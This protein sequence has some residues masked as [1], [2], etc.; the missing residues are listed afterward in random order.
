MAQND[1]K[2]Q[3]SLPYSYTEQSQVDENTMRI[4]RQKS[5]I[6]QWQKLQERKKKA[7]H[8]LNK[9]EINWNLADAYIYRVASQINERY[10]TTLDWIQR[11]FS[12][13]N[14]QPY[15]LNGSIIYFHF[16]PGNQLSLL[17]TE[18]EIANFLHINFSIDEAL[19][20]Y[21]SN[22][23]IPILRTFLLNT[24]YI[25]KQYSPEKLEILF[26]HDG[27]KLDITKAKT[28][29]NLSP[30]DPSTGLPS[31]FNNRNIVEEIKN[32]PK[33]EDRLLLYASSMD[34]IDNPQKYTPEE[35]EEQL[36]P[37]S[38]DSCLE[39][40]LEITEEAKK[41]T[42]KSYLI[43]VLEYGKN[44][45]SN[46]R[47]QLF[48]PLI[49]LITNNPLSLFSFIPPTQKEAYALFYCHRKFFRKTKFE[50]YFPKKADT[51]ARIQDISAKYI[52][53][54]TKK[55]FEQTAQG[56]SFEELETDIYKQLSF[57][58]IP[59]YPFFDIFSQLTFYQ[60]GSPPSNSI[61][62]TLTN[63]NI[64]ECIALFELI[65]KTYL[66]T[67][68][69][70]TITGQ[71][72]SPFT[73]IICKNPF[74]GRAFLCDIFFD[75]LPPSLLY[76]NTHTIMQQSHPQLTQ[77]TNLSTLLAMSMNDILANITIDRE[78]TA[79]MTGAQLQKLNL[80]LKGKTVKYPNNTLGT[81]SYQSKCQYI[82]VAKHNPFHTQ[83]HTE[84]HLS[85]DIT[86]VQY[87]PLAAK[88]K[89][90]LVLSALYWTLAKYSDFQKLP[91]INKEM[92][93]TAPPP[94]DQAI[95]DFIEIS[96]TNTIPSI[97]KNMISKNLSAN[98]HTSEAERDNIRNIL[99]IKNY[100]FT[101]TG[102]LIEAL[103]DWYQA[104]YDS[105]ITWSSNEI[106]DFFKSKYP[107]SFYISYCKA[108]N[109][110]YE[111][112]KKQSSGA[113][114]FYGLKVDYQK[115][116]DEI[117]LAKEKHSSQDTEKNREEFTKYFN[118]IMKHAQSNFEEFLNPSRKFI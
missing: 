73:V 42:L 86:M 8:H 76:R 96:C 20:K 116:K 48:Q 69:Y 91:C 90:E 77:E 108:N 4:R 59:S 28:I 66:G 1:P 109:I 3:D 46:I 7:Q 81:I 100:P 102:D 30:N 36:F 111:Y 32:S 97:T 56:V 74:Y 14:I 53:L 21:F 68:L 95:T 107:K 93:Y 83:E 31:F 54:H 39:H 9:D 106:K 10:P 61:L 26:F 60:N 41:N 84:L 98:S 25:L 65:T 38:L 103:Q 101:I 79:P 34:Y 87:T 15:Q 11:I 57:S 52:L 82:Y 62:Y 2:K 44:C 72:S 71:K 40:T 70:N 45:C 105:S 89:W 94:K 33:R 88:E 51:V 13:M 110:T 75:I 78:N 47:K 113:R 99:H 35:I 112:K 12:I 115:V 92:I 43:P 37:T 114:G 27:T 16:G 50:K 104:K 19:V 80:L 18:K 117:R 17:L 49:T 118:E 64:H 67:E 55:L 58:Q 63:G 6:K 5:T 29:F 24:C 85:G 22:E 23:P